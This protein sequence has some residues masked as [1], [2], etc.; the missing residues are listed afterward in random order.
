MVRLPRMLGAIV[1]ISAALCAACW[2]QGRPANRAAEVSPTSSRLRTSADSP[3]YALPARLPATVI[4]RRYALEIQVDPTKTRFSGRTTIVVELAEPSSLLVLHARDLEI[5]HVVAHVGGREIPVPPELR[6]LRQGPSGDELL[7]RFPAPLPQGSLTLEIDYEAPFASDLSGLFRV[8]E[9]GLDY[10]FTQFEPTDARRAF[11]C[12]DE[13]SFKTPFDVVLV[14]PPAMIAVANAPEAA[15]R[16][17]PDGRVAHRFLT[18]APIPTYLVA[19]A[20]GAFDVVPGRSAP[21]P[22]RVIAPRGGG[23]LAGPA[24]ETASA[25]VDRFADYFGISY[26]FAKLD[27]VAVPDFSAGAMEN[28]GLVTFRSGLLLADSSRRSTGG[29]RAQA[30]VM[31]H[32]LAHQWFGDLVSP[33]WW[34]DLWLSEGF[35]TWAQAR[36]LDDWQPQFEAELGEISRVDRVMDADALVHARSVRAPVR[37]RSD[38]TE[39]FGAIP[40]DKGAAVLRMIEHW[41]GPGIFRR[42]VQ[43]YLNDHAWGN[44]AAEELFSA[45]GYVSTF[46]VDEMVRGFLDH[47]GVPEIRVAWKC[48]SSG[49]STL[50]LREFDWRPLGTSEQVPGHWTVPV[51]VTDT[52]GHGDTCFTLGAE[53]VSR[54]IGPRCPAWIYPNAR[55]SG[56]YR[57]ALDAPKWLALAQNE[58]ALPPADRAGLIANAWA[59]VRAGQLDLTT[60]LG[61]LAR[62]DADDNPIVVEH[63]VRV[64]SGIDHALVDDSGRTP[65]R[66]Y[67]RARL[68]RRKAALGWVPRPRDRGDSDDDERVLASR[69]VLMAMAEIARASD[70]IAQANSYAVRWLEEPSSIPSDVADVAVPMASI[71]AGVRRLQQLRDAAQRAATPEERELALRA[72]GSFTAPDVLR[73]ALDLT[74]TPEIRASEIRFLIGPALTDRTRLSVAIAWE[75]DHWA[76]LLRRA[77]SGLGRRFLVDS[78]GA[79]C[80][81]ADVEDAA[82]FI[83]TRGGDMEGNRRGLDEAIESATLCVAL[84]ARL[85]AS[86]T[87]SLSR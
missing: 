87:K 24:L 36:I 56:Y 25:L 71:D 40:Y 74:L 58:R 63:L 20:I 66:A 2:V 45:L 81:A 46:N 83:A 77:P 55:Q 52:T 37:T 42:G 85:A 5:V 43:K 60:L 22:I 76:D 73:Q 7:L 17:L 14:T 10:S 27:L 65:F 61:L 41:V 19:F 38:A 86:L 53:A 78:M 51:C 26:P 39:A 6:A 9:R 49:R 11:P 1:S 64:L 3:P 30:T 28:P 75:K 32:E 13:P 8:H 68:E 31:A 29:R 57:F 16:V 50:T 84:H 69:D 70:T 48:D 54:E 44:A 72:M 18:T 67:V 34:D 23:S 12:F 35:A 4:P 59:E 33:R 15:S 62:F 80:D 47:A 21:F 82:R 79:I